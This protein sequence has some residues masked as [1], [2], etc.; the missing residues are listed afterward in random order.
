MAKSKKLKFPTKMGSSVSGPPDIPEAMVKP[1]SEEFPLVHLPL[2]M[3]DYR[4]AMPGPEFRL[5]RWCFEALTEIEKALCEHREPVVDY[6]AERFIE[7]VTAL[8]DDIEI[9]GVVNY[10]VVFNVGGKHRVWRPGGTIW[11]DDQSNP[12]LKIP[13]IRP[14]GWQEQVTAEKYLTTTGSERLCALRVLHYRH[15]DE[16]RFY[17]V[18]CRVS[19][20]WHGREVLKAHPYV[21]AQVHTDRTTGLSLG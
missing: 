16:D 9:N 14:Q 19:R 11:V 5:G 12:G 15:P 21:S 20:N 2:S 17:R 13:V 10:L 6:K 4:W 1:P 18:P 3:L 7:P 8:V